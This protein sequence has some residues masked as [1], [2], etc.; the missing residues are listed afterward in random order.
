MKTSSETPSQSSHNTRS[1]K[2]NL[3]SSK[4]LFKDP[5][6]LTT[7]TP[8]KSLEKP[9]PMRTR[10]R[11]V[12]LS[13]SDIRKVAKGLQDQKKQSNE[14][15][16]LKGKSARRQITLAS[17]RKSSESSNLPE[18]YENLGEFFDSLD[19]SI[20]LLR[21]KGSMTSFNNI[22][23]KIETLTDRRFTHAH[24][25]QLKFIL[26]E[27]IAIKKLLVFDERTSCM[28]P[29]LHV[30]INPDAVEFNAKLLSESG[31]MSL[32]KLFR[33]R[34]NEFWKSHPEGDEVPEEMLPEPFS[35][36]KQDPLVHMMK[37]PSSFP[38]VKLSVARASSDIA[39]NTDPANSESHVSVPA[40]TSVEA[41]NQKPAVA[42]H[43]PQSFRRRFSQKL[44]E[45]VQ[46]LQSDSFQ[47]SVVPVSESSL[48][49]NST[50]EVPKIS[51]PEF[52]VESSSSE[53]HPAIHGSSDCFTPSRVT[54]ATPS[55]TIEYA[56]SKDGSF[57][58]VDAMSTPAKFVSTPARLMSAT[59]ALKP[60]KRSFMTPDDNSTSS[61]DKLVKRPPRSRS[62]KFDTPMKNENDAGGLSIDDDIFDIL[63]DNLLHSIQEKERIAMEERD[64]AISQAKKRKKIIASLPKLFNMIHM[65][66]HSINRSVITKE[67][68]MSKIISSHRDIVDRSEVEEQLHLLLELVPEWISEK[69]ASSGDMLVSVNKMLNPESLRASLEEAK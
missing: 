4:S 6:E 61:P 29:D 40:E 46:P 64:P 25:A 47:P 11:G 14:T 37:P 13:I 66:F 54:L 53:A 32:R 50:S 27:A 34:L 5:I 26:P 56:E 12:A 8:E 55:K 20:R 43:M 35:R 24:L 52:V 3:R 31:T 51:P 44:K 33:V 41:L 9:P 7:K 57:K 69:A 36:P 18:K 19:S 58:T 62:L 22:R 60:P 1:K 10:N 15:T 68:L 59:P 45:N 39:D 42:S 16:S 17:P 48:R 49:I 30:S 2:P 21:L 63:P 23:P 38:A 28:K 67:E 65:M